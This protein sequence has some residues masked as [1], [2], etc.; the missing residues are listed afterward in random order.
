MYNV[1]IEIKVL[2]WWILQPKDYMLLGW[3]FGFRA[4]ALLLIT[5]TLNY[6]EIT[7][8]VILGCFSICHQ[9]PC[10]FLFFSP[11]QMFFF[12]SKYSIDAWN[13]AF[14]S[15]FCPA[16][17]KLKLWFIDTVNLALRLLVLDPKCHR[18]VMQSADSIQTDSHSSNL[19][20]NFLIDYSIRFSAESGIVCTPT[21]A[22]MLA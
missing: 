9:P 2:I 6:S 5:T 13:K 1:L 12:V 17:Q 8:L 11:I 22:I 3:C 7:S 16:W 20:E 18:Q 4:I 14:P 21:A 10:F 15:C 19:F